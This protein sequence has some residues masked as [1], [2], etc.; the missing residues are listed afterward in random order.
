M[1][2]ILILLFVAESVNLQA[3]HPQ[4]V[5][6]DSSWAPCVLISGI[7]VGWTATLIGDIIALHGLN[8]AIDLKKPLQPTQ[9]VSTN[10]DLAVAGLV[11]TVTNGMTAGLLHQSQGHWLFFTI[12][13]LNFLGSIAAT[14]GSDI[15]TWTHLEELQKFALSEIATAPIISMVGLGILIPTSILGVRHWYRVL[16]ASIVQAAS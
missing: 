9:V 7:V 11:L 13:G 1:R 14:L 3:M 8:A 16:A 4:P 15:W 2:F 10:Q 12:F 6:V 5:Q